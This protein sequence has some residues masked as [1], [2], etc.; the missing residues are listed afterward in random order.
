[1]SNTKKGKITDLEFDD[2]NFNI[3]INISNYDKINTLNGVLEKGYTIIYAITDG[4]NTIKYIGKTVGYAKRINQ[5]LKDA[6][7]LKTKLYNWLRKHINEI[8]FVILD[9]CENKYWQQIEKGYISL[10]KKNGADLLNTQEG[11]Q[12]IEPGSK[13]SNETKEK[14]SESAKKRVIVFDQS[15]KFEN[16]YRSLSDNELESL[17]YD[18]YVGKKSNAI[19][20]ENYK[21][22]DSTLS[23][24]FNGLRYKESA[25][26]LV[27]KYKNG[28]LDIVIAEKENRKTL[29]K[30]Y[31]E[32]G[33]NDL[34]ISEKIGVNIEK[35]RIYIKELYGQTYQSII[36]QNLHNKII[37]VYNQTKSKKQ[38]SKN[39]GCDYTLVCKIVNKWQII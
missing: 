9:I 1:M 21:I 3:L 26:F 34:E 11:G 2:K 23:Q 8:N 30:S 29:C 7:T 36:S 35:V 5:H 17:F 24:I 31:F 27:D 20:S 39:I 4:L 37:E 32:K 10:F 28:T 38:T 14:L 33:L 25:K 12:G 22:A 13:F 16:M 6:K 18:K 15:K 19:L